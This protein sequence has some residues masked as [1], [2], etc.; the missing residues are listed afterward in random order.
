MHGEVGGTQKPGK[1]TGEEFA[2]M[3]T[4][5]QLGA[6]MLAGSDSP[7]L[8]LGAQIALNHHERWDGTGY[9]QRLQGKQI[10]LAARIVAVADVFDA[11]TQERPY[12]PPWSLLEAVKEILGQKLVKRGVSLKNLTYGKLEPAAG[13]SVKQIWFAGVH[14]DVGPV[15][16]ELLA[17]SRRDGARQRSRRPPRRHRAGLSASFERVAGAGIRET[18]I[19]G[20]QRRLAPCVDAR[21]GPRRC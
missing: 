5:A 14:S 16:D 8:Q 13:Q 6:E 2:V 1:L 17:V 12:K 15:V 10:P 11:L 20:R 21:D 7:V 9:P 19:D 4:H 18:S 3:K